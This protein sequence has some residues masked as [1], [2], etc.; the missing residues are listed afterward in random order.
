MIDEGRAFGA[1]ARHDVVGEGCGVVGVGGAYG[2]DVG[3]VAGR[4]D[5]AVALGAECE[6]AA[7]IAGGRNDDDACLP[8]L[9]Y[10]LTEGIKRVALE[11]WAAQREIDHAYVVGIFECDGSLDGLDDGGV[12]TL[13]IPIEHLEVDEVYVGSSTEESAEVLVAVRGGPVP[14]DKTRDMRAVAVLILGVVGGSWH[15]ALAV[16]NTA[17]CAWDRN[18]TGGRRKQSRRV[19]AG[20]H[21]IQDLGRDGLEIFRDID[22]AVN[23]SDTDAS[24]VEAFG[25]GRGCVDGLNCVFGAG[26]YRRVDVAR[27]MARDQTVRTDV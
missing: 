16:D 1:V 8:G 20:H 7:V 17:V 25:P 6:I 26:G 24:T 14:A 3:V 13:A 23:N 11:D 10:G 22:P 4:F 27:G 5:G 21:G 19:E 9:L 12:S 2:E 15:E 18:E